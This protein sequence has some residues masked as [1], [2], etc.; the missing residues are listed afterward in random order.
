MRIILIII[1]FTC[2]NLSAQI[3]TDVYIK[4][5]KAISIK[6]LQN[7][8]HLN[9]DDCWE[10]HSEEAKIANGSFDSRS[11]LLEKSFQ[12]QFDC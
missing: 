3:F 5:A 4:D 2:Q 10:M 9:F 8:N 11:L 1:I 6:W 7:L 12:P